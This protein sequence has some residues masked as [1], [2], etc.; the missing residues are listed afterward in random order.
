MTS[1]LLLSGSPSRPSRTAALL[2]DAAQHL[3]LGGHTA[4]RI[5]VLDLP[6]AAL[7][8][9]DT[10]H[11]AIQ[12]ALAAVD[13]ADALVI[14]TPVY[15]A[16]FSGVLKT[17]LD[18]LPQKALAGKAVLP[19]ATGG[20]IAHL[21]SIDYALRPVLQSLSPRHVAPGRF[22]LDTHLVK[23]GPGRGISDPT[24]RRAVHQ[25]VEQFVA[26]SS[27]TQSSLTEPALSA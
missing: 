9:A 20:T 16:S 26:E 3:D 7:L 2:D 5:D 18:L 21:L 27:T 12:N 1:F 10:T 24:A 19:L 23:E 8:R 4:T 25:A 17:F 15:K 13:L 14:G 22:V 11:P 6:A